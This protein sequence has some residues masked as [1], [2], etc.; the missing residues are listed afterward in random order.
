[1][2]YLV[3]HLNPQFGQPLSLPW[4]NYLPPKPPWPPLIYLQAKSFY[5]SHSIRYFFET[6]ISDLAQI[7]PSSE[8]MNFLY[9]LKQFSVVFSLDWWNRQKVWRAYR[10]YRFV[11]WTFNFFFNYKP[12]KYRPKNVFKYINLTLLS[13]WDVE[14][15]DVH[16]LN[17]KP[18]FLISL[19]APKMCSQHFHGR[20]H[21]L[22][23]RFVP[24]P[25]TEK[26]NLQ[27]PTY[28]SLDSFVRL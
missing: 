15:G 18:D 21:Y 22:G 7:W 16:G 8:F 19:T 2:P 3:S 1:M 26:Y 27:L 17:L 25:L 10:I 6:R 12:Y 24:R 4:S 20:F 28:P 23:G 14:K 13:G 9:F 11:S 5:T